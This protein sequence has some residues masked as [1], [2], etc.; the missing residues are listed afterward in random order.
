[1][2]LGVGSEDLVRQFRGWEIVSWTSSPEPKGLTLNLRSPR[3]C[4]A[5]QVSPALDDAADDDYVPCSSMSP[6]IDLNPPSR[7]GPAHKSVFNN[8]NRQVIAGAAAPGGVG[9]L[10]GAGSNVSRATRCGHVQVL[11]EPT[12]VVCDY[13][14]DIMVNGGLDAANLKEAV[15]RALA[16]PTRVNCASAQDSGRPS[17]RFD[18]SPVVRMQSQSIA[19]V[20]WHRSDSSD[21]KLLLMSPPQRELQD[22]PQSQSQLQ[23]AKLQVPQ[24]E[25]AGMGKARYNNHFTGDGVLDLRATTVGDV[26][27]ARSGQVLRLG[28]S[29]AGV[30]APWDTSRPHD[31]P[32]WRSDMA[33]QDVQLQQQLRDATD[34][35]G[36]ELYI[37]R[38]PFAPRA[39]THNQLPC[40]TLDD[41]PI[42]RGSQVSPSGKELW[43]PQLT[44][45]LLIPHA[46]VSHSIPNARYGDQFPVVLTVNDGSRGEVKRYG[47]SATEAAAEAAATSG[48]YPGALMVQRDGSGVLADIHIS[49]AIAKYNGWVTVG[50]HIAKLD[51]SLGGVYWVEWRVHKPPPPVPAQL[52]IQPQPVLQPRQAAAVAAARQRCDRTEEANANDEG[53]LLKALQI[54][55]WQQKALEEQLARM[56]AR[57]VTQHE[58]QRLDLHQSS[59][60]ELKGLLP[61]QQQQQGDV[62]QGDELQAHPVLL[63]QR[64]NKVLGSTIVPGPL[65]RQ[66]Q[67]P[68]ERI[69]A[70]AAQPQAERDG[71]TEPAKSAAAFG[72]G[73]AGTADDAKHCVEHTGSKKYDAG[74]GSRDLLVAIASSTCRGSRPSKRCVQGRMAEA[75]SFLMRHPPSGPQPELSKPPNLPQLQQQQLQPPRLQLKAEAETRL[76]SLKA[77]EVTVGTPS[78][79]GSGNIDEL[80][81]TH[82][83]SGAGGNVPSSPSALQTAQGEAIASSLPVSG[84]AEDRSK[85]FRGPED[86]TAAAEKQAPEDGLRMAD[87]V[88]AKVAPLDT[89]EGAAPVPDSAPPGSGQFQ[90]SGASLGTLPTPEDDLV[91]ARSAPRQMSRYLTSGEIRV[92]FTE[93]DSRVLCNPPCGLLLMIQIF[94]DGQPLGPPQEAQLCRYNGSSP[95]YLTSVPAQELTSP[96]IPWKR[97]AE[98]TIQYRRCRS[99][100]LRL[101]AT[102]RRGASAGRGPEEGVLQLT[103]KA[104]AGMPKLVSFK[105]AGLRRA[106]WLAASGSGAGDGDCG[107]IDGYDDGDDDGD[108]ISGN[109]DAAELS[110]KPAPGSLSAG[111]VRGLRSCSPAGCIDSNGAGRPDSAGVMPATQ[112]TNGGFGAFPSSYDGDRNGGGRNFTITV[113]GGHED[114]AH[115]TEHQVQGPLDTT[116]ARGK[117]EGNRWG[118]DP[119]AGPIGLGNIPNDLNRGMHYNSL[120]GE[121][122]SVG[123][124]CTAVQRSRAEAAAACDAADE[125]PAGTE[126]QFCTEVLV[127]CRPR[128]LSR[129]VTKAE[130]EL[131]VGQEVYEQLCGGNK[132]ADVR[133]MFEVNGR[134]HPEVFIADIER[135]NASSPFYL[136][137][138]SGRGVDGLPWR[139]VPPNATVQWRRMADNTLVLAQVSNT[140]HWDSNGRNTTEGRISSSQRRG[141]IGTTSKHRV[142]AGRGHKNDLSDDEYGSGDTKNDVQPSQKRRRTRKAARA[143]QPSQGD[144]LLEALAGAAGRALMEERRNGVNE[145]EEGKDEDENEEAGRR[146]KS[147]DKVPDLVH[148]S[149]ESSASPAAAAGEPQI[150]GGTDTHHHREAGDG[151]T[152]GR[153]LSLLQSVACSG[154]LGVLTCP[155]PPTQSQ[156]TAG[157]QGPSSFISRIVATNL[158]IGRRQLQALYGPGFKADTRSDMQLSLNGTLAPDIYH[159]QW[160]EGCH[161]GSFYPKGAVSYASRHPRVHRFLP[162]IIYLKPGGSISF[163]FAAPLRLLSLL[164]RQFHP[165]H[166]SHLSGSGVHCG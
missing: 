53:T 20:Q 164:T 35:T 104:A 149:H 93:R 75:V 8:P 153:A 60:D 33:R 94:L 136:K 105:P 32:A 7:H 64:Q 166:R 12:V 110:L 3:S 132:L 88:E 119:F 145:I 144:D 36:P 42:R 77:V 134:R 74:V 18:E 95:R 161:K 72:C 71:G 21:L 62:N 114:A 13:E 91:V 37:S 102:R 63:R 137:A 154:G 139:S 70:D 23:H 89:N 127:A 14:D 45:A 48:H 46:F 68:S 120:L 5:L 118:L 151:A 43:E 16:L 113:G 78:P 4:R 29:N 130:L 80:K 143:W 10:A 39:P 57:R 73:L 150:P 67:L 31:P 26:R 156:L 124:R 121:L 65:Q 155:S 100:L 56:Q 61:L 87:D 162:V 52:S 22:L 79:A 76:D 123:G 25:E 103:A 28:G 83:P 158:Y 40:I 59:P 98:T 55:V 152:A 51:E 115:A 92:L 34:G 117:L 106:A 135:Y 107:G 50:W 44:A 99:G 49:E 122:R 19:P 86:G 54:L 9:I 96:P 85:K 82:S 27:D 69:R 160:K 38:D 129:Y 24:S 97:L 6:V 140:T 159:V 81:S 125:S 90:A 138:A 2:R 147:N 109:A 66:P 116:D 108:G 148:R 47:M 128:S 111:A 133:V 15:T 58:K 1:M 157:N 131:L 101:W 163:R 126:P 146:R 30:A 84:A 142:S 17:H 112:P 41:P 165:S 11:T 141:S